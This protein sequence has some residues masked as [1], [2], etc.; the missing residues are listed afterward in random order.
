MPTGVYAS[1]M[2]RLELRGPSTRPRAARRGNC[3]VALRL[4][5]NVDGHRFE[6]GRYAAFTQE[7][8]DFIPRERQYTDPVR[9]L[10]YGTDASFYRL[11]PKMV[12]KVGSTRGVGVHIGVGELILGGECVFKGC[13]L[14]GRTPASTASTRAIH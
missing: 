7:I 6:D 11:N 8:S 2:R 9:T 3:T 1:R 4:H 14:K 12:V 10:A 13:V 5:R